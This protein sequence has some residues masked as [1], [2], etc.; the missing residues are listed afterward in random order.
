MKSSN[1]LI[2]GDNISFVF[3]DSG[4]GLPDRV[5]VVPKKEDPGIINTLL[6][7]SLAL[8]VCVALLVLRKYLKSRKEKISSVNDL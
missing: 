8:A 4:I 6:I 2:S 1:Y 7:V 3:D 5:V